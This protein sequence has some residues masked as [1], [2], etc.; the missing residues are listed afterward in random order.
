MEDL[1]Q[2]DA[3]INPGNSGGA[4][5][6]VDGEMIGINTI[7]ITSAEGIGFAV[8]INIVKPIIESY[9]KTGEFEE[10]YIG[11]SGIKD[12]RSTIAPI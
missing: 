6:N 8:P 1:I 2:T 10:A 4:L 5:I 3:T 11:I 9:I 7:K 12:N